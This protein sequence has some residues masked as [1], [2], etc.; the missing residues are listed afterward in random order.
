MIWTI[1]RIIQNFRVNKGAKFSRGTITYFA[2]RLGYHIKHSGGLIGYDKSL[3]TVLTSH[4][5]EMVKYQNEK[6]IRK[7]QR[8]S[9]REIDYNPDKFIE[10]EDRVD[11]DWEKN[12]S[13]NMKQIIRLT[14][15][16]L[17]R[18][19]KES[20]RIILENSTNEINHIAEKSNVTIC[21]LED[22]K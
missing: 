7:A 5:P 6:D 8:A 22:F 3:Y 18:L 11:Y 21:S 20:V 1:N 9:K 13:R 19:V 16:D 10:P 17:H 4:Y 14:E 2:T 15:S 12:E